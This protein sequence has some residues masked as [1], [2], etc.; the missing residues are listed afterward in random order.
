[1]AISVIP[2]SASMTI[3]RRPRVNAPNVSGAN[4]MFTS[5]ALNAGGECEIT[6]AAG[7]NPAGW[8]LGLIQL[9]WIETNWGYYRGQTNLDGSSFLQRARPPARPKQGCRDTLTVGAVF[10]DNNPGSDRTVAVAGQRFPI[11][12]AARFPDGPRDS[13]PL[14]RTNSLTRKTNF[15]REVQLEFHFC[16]VLSLRSPAGTY[17]HL[18]HFMWNTHWQ[19]RFRPTNFANVAAPWTI[20]LTGGR[21][22]NMAAVSRVFSG[23]PTDRRFAPIITAAAAPNCNRTATNAAN[24]PNARE[25]RVW[26]NFDVRR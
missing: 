17:Q 26:A 10:V 24:S 16:T 18:K 19:A 9:Q 6:G 1:M 23:G 2:R 3:T 22:G 13:Y 21:L 25:S 7:D 14:T 12:M 4:M 20:T 11:K 8:T 5:V 15:L